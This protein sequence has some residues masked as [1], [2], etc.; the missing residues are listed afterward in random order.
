MWWL[1]TSVCPASVCVFKIL[2][3]S[4]SPALF[5]A[6]TGYLRKGQCH[7]LIAL[8]PT[9]FSFVLL[10]CFLTASHVALC[11]MSNS[12]QWKASAAVLRLKSVQ[13]CVSFCL[14]VCLFFFKQHCRVCCYCCCWVVV[15]PDML[16]ILSGNINVFCVPVPIYLRMSFQCFCK[17]SI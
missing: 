11:V 14:K 2:F 17:K 4:L 1:F 6:K 7:V 16:K 9:H 15:F 3:F 5:K 8:L 12:V 13:I 10:L